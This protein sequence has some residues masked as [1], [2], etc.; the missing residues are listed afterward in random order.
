[1]IERVF[2]TG[3]AGAGKTT[4]A[5]E[6]A[7]RWTLPHYEMDLGDATQVDPRTRWIVEGATLWD[8]E[9]FLD[10]AQLVVWLDLPPFATI[11]RIVRRHVRLSI[12]GENRH[13]GVRLLVRFVRAQPRYYRAP[14]R[15]P[16]GPLDFS[17]TRAGTRQVLLP[18]RDRVVRLGSARAVRRWT[19][20]L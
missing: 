3:G 19:S 9:R 15:L 7:A 5:H 6:L 14:P 16:T 20:A 4:L 12:G 1:M 10:E 18:Y 17:Q 13:R 11:P 8:V 2:V